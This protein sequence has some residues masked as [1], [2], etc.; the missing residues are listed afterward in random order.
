MDK[1]Q[2]KSPPVGV[3]SATLCDGPKVWALR[4]AA[5]QTQQTMNT[6][7]KSKG[8][9]SE[10]EPVRQRLVAWRQARKHREGILQNLW[11]AMTLL[12]RSH[13]VNPVCQALRIDYYALKRRVHGS[14]PAKQP[15]FVELPMLAPA[16]SAGDVIELEDKRG[17]KMTLRLDPAHRAET[18]SLIQTFWRQA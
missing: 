1:H 6:K 11:E 4:F 16:G 3:T 15:G 17:R 12:G 7:T 5:K 13:G 10:I 18:L 2:N 9:L 14:S 8:F